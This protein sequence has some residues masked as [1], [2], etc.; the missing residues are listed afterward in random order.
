MSESISNTIPLLD[1]G[2]LELI[3]HMGNDMSVVEAARVSFLGESKGEEKDKKLIHY[4]MKNKH[5]SPFES[6]VFK[7]RVKCP[8]FIRS[9]WMR[10]RTWSYNE[11]S[12][13]YTSENIEFYVPTDWRVQDHNNKQGSFLAEQ[14][15]QIQSTNWD[16]QV[17]ELLEKSLYLYNSMINSGVA[18]EMARMVLPQNLYTIFYGTVNLNNLFKFLKLRND[19]HAQHEIK[20]YAEAI[21]QIVQRLVPVSYEAWKLYG[22]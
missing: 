8:L 17:L 16:V 12:R 19:S 14:G 20:V 9:Q 7:F 13:R 10:H 15:A 22:I 21:E 2:Y 3:D 18:R 4:L 11:I 1:K 6:V 5:T